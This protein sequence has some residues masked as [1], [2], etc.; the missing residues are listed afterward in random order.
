MRLHR[1]SSSGKRS[2][3]LKLGAY[4]GSCALIMEANSLLWSSVNGVQVEA[5]VDISLLYIHQSKTVLWSGGIKQWW[6]WKG[7]F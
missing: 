1:Q 5:F 6:Q 3:K 4:S 2:W 7:A